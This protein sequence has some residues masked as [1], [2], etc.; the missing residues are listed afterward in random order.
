ML[1]K[2][3]PWPPPTKESFWGPRAQQ[4]L[5]HLRWQNMLDP[6]VSASWEALILPELSLP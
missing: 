6:G 1:R 5:W 2:P 3:C 4:T